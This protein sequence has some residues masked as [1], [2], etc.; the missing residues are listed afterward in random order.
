MIDNANLPPRLSNVETD[1]IF[2]SQLSRDSSV[3]EPQ[4]GPVATSFH[5]MLAEGLIFFLFKIKVVQIA[6]RDILQACKRRALHL[7][8]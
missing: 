4:V 2:L 1:S 7:K 6:V 5:K 3:P 8:C